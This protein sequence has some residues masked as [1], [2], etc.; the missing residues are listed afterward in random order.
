M[1]DCTDS[2]PVSRRLTE[3]AQK[4]CIPL[5][6]TMELTKQC[7]LS[8]VHCYNFDRSD[9]TKLPRNELRSNEI[10]KLIDELATLGTL[11]LSFSGGEATIDKNLE[12]YIRRA[13]KHFMQVGLKSN[14]IAPDGL[15]AKLANA[16]V[17]EFH[18]SLYGASPQTHDRITTRAGSFKRTLAGIEAIAKTKK[19]LRLNY[20]VPKTS[21]HEIA[22]MKAIA[23]Q[24]QAASSFVFN[25]T[26]RYDGTN[27]PKS[28]SLGKQEL[29]NLLTNHFQE[30]S[31]TPDFNPNR[32]MDCACAKTNC[33]ITSTGDVYPCIGC[34]IPSG[35]IRQQ[36]IRE[37]WETSPQFL[38]IRGLSSNDF[39][40]CKSCP[41][42]P[43][44]SRSSGNTMTNTGKYTGADEWTCM[45]ASV[46]RELYEARQQNNPTLLQDSILAP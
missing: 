12:S 16:G 10:L 46:Q 7:N 15:Y 27:E 5:T 39:K 14:G 3:L 33:G 18:I 4:S 11:F 6:V 38:K 20:I 43:Y 13:R 9:P 42:K 32:N 29:M 2:R 36:S 24:Y 17:S 35:N 44:C 19:H 40:I 34:P 21:A 30:P 41:D 31:L 8:C 45:A 26:G 23:T 37:I 25:F 22:Q 28:L 1:T